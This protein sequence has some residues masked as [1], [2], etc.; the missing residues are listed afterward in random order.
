MEIDTT[1]YTRSYHAK[2]YNILNRFYVKHRNSNITMKN[3][4]KMPWD[5]NNNLCTFHTV[6]TC[7]GIIESLLFM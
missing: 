3:I 4:S 6:G 7:K 2:H 5:L 1:I